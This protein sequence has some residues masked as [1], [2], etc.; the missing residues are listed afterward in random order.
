MLKRIYYLWHRKI[1]ERRHGREEASFGYWQDK[2]RSAAFRL[3]D[4]KEGCILEVGCGEGLFLQKAAGNNPRLFF[5]GVDISAAQLARAKERLGFAGNNSLSLAQ[6]D[7]TRLPFKDGV[8]DRVICINVLLNL[9]REE[10][11]PEVLSEIMRVCKKRGSII[12]D[13]RNKANPLL[14]L[15]YKLVRYYDGTIDSQHL[16]MHWLSHIERILEKLGLAVARKISIGFPFSS[17]AP[18]VVIEA[19]RK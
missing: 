10:M 5:W 8:F 15:K 9:P 13:I 3:S 19:R 16:K 1:S 14:Y 11:V 4:L 6:A 7:A 2:V 12:F 17:L 18:I